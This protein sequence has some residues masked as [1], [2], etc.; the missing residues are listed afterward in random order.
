MDLPFSPLFS[1]KTALISQ[2]GVVNS[3]FV[4]RRLILS[5]SRMAGRYFRLRGKRSPVSSRIHIVSSPGI[6]SM[7]MMW[8]AFRYS[9]PVSINVGIC[10]SFHFAV[11]DLSFLIPCVDYVEYIIR[12]EFHPP[13]QVLLNVEGVF[14]IKICCVLV[15][16]VLCKVIFIRAERPDTA[17]LEDAFPAVQDSKLVPAHQLFPKLLVVCAVAGAVAAGIGGV[18]GVDGL[19]PEGFRQFLQRRRFGTAEEYLGV[20]VANDGVSV[21]L[22]DRFQLGPCLQHQACADLTAPDGGD[23]LF[24]VRDLADV[25]HLIDQAPDMDREP[26]AIDIVRFLAEQVEE[27][28]V[29][30]TDQEIEGAVRIA[31]DQEQRR[32]LI[33]QG[34]QFQF[35]VGRQFPELLDIEYGKPCPAGDKDA[36]RRLPGC[37]L[38]FLVLPDR[39]VLRVLF[40]QVLKHDIHRVLEFLIILAD[41]HGVDELDQGGKVLLFFW[42]LVVDIPYQGTVEQGLRFCPEFVTGFSVAFGVGDQCGDELQDVLLAV[43]IGEGVVM[44]ALFE[45]DGV[46]DPDLVSVLLQG[47]AA[48]QDDG[49]FGA[50]AVKILNPSNSFTFEGI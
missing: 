49:A 8:V 14:L 27:L 43:D 30:H 4:Y 48:L 11:H 25:C 13:V 19:L 26:A 23:Q 31:H 18:V 10:R 5:A 6:V 46:Q 36:F 41:L 3:C 50:L 29:R 22:V 32:F 38:I 15:V 45:I 39:E 33:P 34:I 12:V 16:R 24:Q 40:L 44:H 28:G 47:V 9:S 42:C 2:G 37:K 20:H 35:V 7:L 21:V 1:E 17:K